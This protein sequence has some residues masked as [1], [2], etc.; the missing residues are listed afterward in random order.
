MVLFLKILGGIAAVALG[1]YLG[2][3]EN[4]QSSEEMGQRLGRGVPRKAKRHFMWLNYMKPVKRASARRAKRNYFRTAT[5]TKDEPG[6][7]K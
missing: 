1:I 6:Q 5:S 3:G 7:S 2:L 4:H